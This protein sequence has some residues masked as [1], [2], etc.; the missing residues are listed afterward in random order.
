MLST[1]IFILHVYWFLI[2]FPHSTTCLLQLFASFFSKT[3]PSRFISTSMW[4]DFATFAPPPRLFQPP[5]LLERWEYLGYITFDFTKSFLNFTCKTL[6][7]WVALPPL[8]HSWISKIQMSV[9]QGKNLVLIKDIGYA[10]WHD[11]RKIWYKGW[12]QFT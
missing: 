8:V 12:I 5:Q 7:S 6:F 4:I 1:Y 3:S 9:T 10:F 11:I 2:V